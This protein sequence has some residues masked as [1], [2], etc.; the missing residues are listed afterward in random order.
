MRDT[1]KLIAFYVLCAGLPLV[2]RADAGTPLL[3]ATFGHLLI[4]NAIIG[5]LEGLILAFGFKLGKIRS[6]LLMIV[7]NYFSSWLGMLVLEATLPTFPIDINNARSWYWC[8]F[9]ASYLF[10]LCAEY[11]FIAL[12]FGR[13][14]FNWKR[15]LIA[16]LCV[17]TVSYVLLAF[18]YPVYEVNTLGQQC[19]V[20]PPNA[21]AIPAG[22]RIYY[23]ADD[24]KVCSVDA[25]SLNAPRHVYDCATTNADY[26]TALRQALAL[27]DYHGK[28]ISPA[29]LD[30]YAPALRHAADCGT[31]SQWHVSGMNFGWA[32]DGLL[33]TRDG[34]SQDA[35][36]IAYDTLFGSFS[37]G[38]CTLLPG[39]I[40]LFQFGRDQICL[41]DIGTRRLSMIA[42]GHSPVPIRIQP[43]EGHA[44]R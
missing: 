3:W 11:P 19:E 37:S 20:V 14:S 30:Q 28:T 33:C 43:G 7:A 44:D 6:I 23:I 5:L 9:A 18:W 2:A 31:N 17:Q 39:N 8:L 26:D 25:A 10:T 13:K 16:N 27:H 34:S 1:R 32:S 41:L 24:N 40:V 35:I 42:H 15:S 4:G 22:I 12:A 21:I 29:V 36:H 38:D